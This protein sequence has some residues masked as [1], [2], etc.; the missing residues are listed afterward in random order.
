MLKTWLP[1]VRF[2]HLEVVDCDSFAVVN[3]LIRR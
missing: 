1:A 2:N 3:E